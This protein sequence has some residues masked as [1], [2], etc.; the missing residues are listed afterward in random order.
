MLTF[1]IQS[2]LS[3]VHW[4]CGNMHRHKFVSN[5]TYAAHF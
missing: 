4:V 3:N 2:Y 5:Q 1:Q